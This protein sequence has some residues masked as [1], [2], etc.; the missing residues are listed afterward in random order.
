M[1]PPTVVISGSDLTAA[2]VTTTEVVSNTFL[3]LRVQIGEDEGVTPWAARPRQEGLGELPRRGRDG[4]TVGHWQLV[5]S[6]V[7][8]RGIQRSKLASTRG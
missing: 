3:A 2:F 7:A 6:V 5:G 4:P 8:R 1:G